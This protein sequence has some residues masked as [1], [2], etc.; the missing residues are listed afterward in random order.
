[1]KEHRRPQFEYILFDLDETLYPKEAGLMAAINERIISFMTHHV[2]IP[3]DDVAL[4]KRGYYQKYGTSLRGLMEE[5]YIDPKEFL[6]YVHDIN[7]RDFFGP[8]PPLDHMLRDV[9]LHKV[10]FTNAD[11][12]HSERVLNTLQ[13]RAHFEMIIDI[14]AVNFKS[15][16]DP[17]AYKRALEILGVPGPSCIMVDDRPRNLIPARD[18]GMT[19]ILVG[20]D[21]HSIAIDYT[22]P[23]IFH[24]ERILKK[25]LPNSLTR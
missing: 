2:G 11:A 15:K 20:N 9:P 21:C 1:M 12:A 8:S 23:T 25:L 16:P 3:A 5:H 22:V 19:T 14:E 7:P 10:I 13:V 24:A 17:Q 4:K 6:R 18:L